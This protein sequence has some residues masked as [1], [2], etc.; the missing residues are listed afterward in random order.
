MSR[1]RKRYIPLHGALLAALLA[2][3]TVVPAWAA[4]KALEDLAGPLRQ[5]AL[6]A[7]AGGIGAQAFPLLKGPT[8]TVVVEIHYQSPAAASGTSLVPYGG[9]VQF[10]RD[11][12]VQAIVP[13]S[14]L[15]QIAALPQV[16]Q[17]RAPL[18]PVPLQG[19]GA[20]TSEGVQLTGAVP[21]HVMGIVG[22]GV[23]LAIID[24][25]FNDYA[26]AEVPIDPNDPARAVSFTIGGAMTGDWHGTA[27]AEVVA[28]M[29]YGATFTLINVDTN[30]AWETAID[31]VRRQGFDVCSVSLGAFGGPYDGTTPLD[32]EVNRARA[33]DVFYVNADGN[34]AQDHYQGDWSDRNGNGYQEFSGGDEAIDVYLMPGQFIAYLS[35]WETTP[36]GLTNHD[37]DLVL[38]DGTGQEVA[39]SGF[40]QNG[41]DQPLDVLVAYITTEGMYGLK[42]HYYG[43]PPIHQDRFQLFTP[44]ISLEAV[45][46]V[47]E[48]SLSM[49]SAATGCY[50]VGATRGALITGSP[51]GDLPVDALEPFSSQGPVAGHPERIK[52]DL[53]APDGVQTSLTAQ[54]LD[55]FYGTSAA[56]P[57]VAGAAALL[58]SEDQL[59]TADEVENILNMQ[60]APL[61]DPVPNNEFGHG[62]LNLRIGAD[63][64][65]PRIS[66]AYPQ[67]GD[68]ITTLTP[69]VTAYITDDGSGVDPSTIVITLDG[70]V[71]LDASDPAVDIND[72]FNAAN[73][74]LQWQVPSALSRTSHVVTI[75]CSDLAGN[76]ADA[77]ITNFR[78]AAPTIA[79][80][81]HIV[82]FPYWELRETDPSIILG[83]PLSEMALVRWAP[84]DQGYDKYHFYPD[85]LAT[86]TPTDTQ[87]ADINERTVPYPPAGLGYFL[88]LPQTAVLNIEGRSVQEFTSVHVR[89]RHG[90]YPPR[91]WNL[92]GNPYEETTSWGSVQFITNGVAQDLGEAI[93]AGVTEGVLFDYVDPGGGQPGYYDF[94]PEP[95]Q[96]VMDPQKGYWVHV[97]EDTRVVFYSTAVASAEAQASGAG[98]DAQ[99]DGWT[100]KLS[101][102]AGGLQDP[103]NYIGV[104]SAATAGYDPRYDVPEP[105]QLG[106]GLQM[107]MNHTGWGANSGQYAKD[108]RGANDAGV[109]DVQVTC[110]VPNTPVSV[111]WPEL[112]SQV[113]ADVRLMLEDLETRRQVYMRT[114]SR[115]EFDSGPEGGVRHL[116]ITTEPVGGHVLTISAV[117]AQS[118]TGGAAITYTLSLSADVTVEIRNIAGRLVRSFAA[119]TVE[120]G[121]QQTLNWNGV[122]NYGSP[123]PAG[124]YLVRLTARADDG[125][126]V[127]AI[128]PLNVAR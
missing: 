110:A 13:V 28:D 92:I 68:T 34:F 114:S 67:N 40:T 24:M 5:L 3:G 126:T 10:C 125:Q 29:A 98:A 61:G 71:V 78:V 106:K 60:A 18:C 22:Q 45:H 103:S 27:C 52:P 35:W 65:P 87:Q 21:Y 72:Y 39:R 102:S 70:L 11:R 46:Q 108:V 83:T 33:A 120:A 84:Q 41:D 116:R 91:G 111:S 48:S 64:R 42:V 19:F 123:V 119:R 128:R 69:T 118:V 1:L 36:T 97:N 47:A 62:R 57:H 55:P 43:G 25:G 63:S 12:R 66:I 89:L 73:G 53:V 99:S 93:D 31:Y 85:A 80:G 20:R 38:V 30:M 51:A 79:A 122:G 95:T 74:R 90:Q 6:Q 77:A 121:T 76:Q 8:D 23:D 14:S 15:S 96:A 115:Y 94:N 107:S 7:A 112:N 100:L 44:N 82:S 17:I 59:R 127:Q 54:G 2:V 124:R 58:L 81:V 75:Q 32:Q 117:S 9:Q 105:P 101:A 26:T 104:A 50:A 37:Y 16:T 4:D 49:P 88:S 109:W 113:P 86:L 56:A